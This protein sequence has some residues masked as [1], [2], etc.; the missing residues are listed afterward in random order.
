MKDFIHL[1]YIGETTSPWHVGRLPQRMVRERFMDYQYTRADL[2][3]GRGIRGPVLRQLWR[4]HCPHSDLMDKTDFNPQ[5]HCIQC[6]MSPE[7]PFNN[8]RGSDDEGEWKDRPRLILT[9]LKFTLPRDFQPKR[10][11]FTTLSARD[12]GTA[13]GR[14]PYV[15]EYIP[16]GTRFSFEAILMAE[17]AHFEGDFDR[18]VRVSLGFFGWGGRCNE[19]FGRGKILDCERNDF[20]RFWDRY[21]DKR[22]EG[23]LD[24]GE[25]ELSIE[26]LLI[27]DKDSGGYYTSSLEPGFAEKFC[28][29]INE[30]FWQ[31]RGE[32]VHLQEVVERVD[33]GRPGILR[34]WSRKLSH[35]IFF[36]GIA[37]SI[38]VVLSRK[39]RMEETQALALARYGIG[40][41]KNQGFGAMFLGG[42]S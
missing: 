32:H 14:G 38:R 13:T 11:T 19:G 2:M 9:N 28:N 15:V 8:L 33:G 6:P 23:M 21:I 12:L 10:L 30:R 39:L 40:R 22:A 36:R 16:P 25:L 31:F 34:G 26:T 1:R 24:G 42:E 29:C 20:D 37:G 4:S 7:C 17:G 18:A 27:L 5:R 35:E 3:W 41:Y